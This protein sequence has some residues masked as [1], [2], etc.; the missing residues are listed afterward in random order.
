VQ[1]QDLGRR[2]QTGTGHVGYLL[3][4]N[5]RLTAEYTYDFIGKANS[6]SLGFV[7]AF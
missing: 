1:L 2:Y 5:L 3:A 6:V 7:S 4:R